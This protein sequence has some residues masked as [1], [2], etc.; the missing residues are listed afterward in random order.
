MSLSTTL[1][2]LGLCASGCSSSHDA[3]AQQSGGDGDGDRQGTDSPAAVGDG[4]GD[5]AVQGDADGIQTDVGPL[6]Q[7]MHLQKSVNGSWATRSRVC[8]PL[9][10]G[11]L[12]AGC[13]GVKWQD[14]RPFS[15]DPELEVEVCL[16]DGSFTMTAFEDQVG[17]QDAVE[18]ASEGWDPALPLGGEAVGLEFTSG[19]GVQWR[20]EYAHVAPD[21]CTP[22]Y[23]QEI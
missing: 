13:T 23:D 16:Q 3:G 4:D 12:E 5:D 18:L 17:G 7:T 20:F 1:L 6:V 14:S 11:G 15:I 10:E 19:T 22:V 21:S 9:P 8:L 2:L